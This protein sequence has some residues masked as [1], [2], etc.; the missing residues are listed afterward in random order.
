MSNF[1]N[2]SIVRIRH[3]AK[4]G[5]ADAQY[6]LALRYD[7]NRGTVRDY[8][9]AIKWYRKAAKQGDVHAQYRLGEM[10]ERGQGVRIDYGK[11]IAWYRGAARQGHEIAQVTLGDAYHEGLI[12]KRNSDE[13]V[14]WYRLA[15][16][17]GNLLAQDMLRVLLPESSRPWDPKSPESRGPGAE[18]APVSGA[19]R[20]LAWASLLL[21]V[22][23]IFLLAISA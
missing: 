11:A 6:E 9:K 21:V 2:E 12:V 10:Y 23:V 17:Q 5:N 16:E 19:G 15:A 13:A 14:R 8:T 18:E 1:W 3:A 7:G 20:G 22:F 4:L